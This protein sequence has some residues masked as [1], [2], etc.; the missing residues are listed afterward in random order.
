MHFN[1]SR[2]SSLGCKS[3][4]LWERC[5]I[6][7]WGEPPF[8]ALKARWNKNQIN[9]KHNKDKARC[10]IFKNTFHG[11]RGHVIIICHC[12]T[13]RGGQSLCGCAAPPSTAASGPAQPAL[14]SCPEAMRWQR[15]P[16]H[17]ALGAQKMNPKGPP[18]TG[19]APRPCFVGYCSWEKSPD[20]CSTPEVSGV[21]L[22]KPDSSSS[23]LL[24]EHQSA[25][26]QMP[27]IENKNILCNI[28]IPPP[29]HLVFCV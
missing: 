3:R 26:Q 15:G 29:N 21:C 12:V 28:I 7:N 4:L 18:D 27:V 6:L 14:P 25:I 5:T 10:Y 13:R 9:K 1:S 17:P 16:H 11:F 22:Y 24:F 23:L 2:S 19:T 20:T 8:V